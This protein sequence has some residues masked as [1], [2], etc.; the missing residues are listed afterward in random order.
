MALELLRSKE[1][2]LKDFGGQGVGLLTYKAIWFLGF[3]DEGNLR[4][5][6]CGE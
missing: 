4:N 3:G 1:E 6:A 2:E 5:L